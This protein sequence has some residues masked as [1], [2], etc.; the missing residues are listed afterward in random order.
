M[1]H[2]KDYIGWTVG[3]VSTLGE[4]RAV[5]AQLTPDQL[6]FVCPK[7]VEWRERAI[8]LQHEPA[9]MAA[10]QMRHW[11]QDEKLADAWHNYQRGE[12]Q[13]EEFEGVVAEMVE[14]RERHVAPAD[15]LQVGDIV[16]VLDD[17][18]G[19]SFWH[20][21]RGPIV[22]IK[23]WH[24]ILELEDMKGRPTEVGGWS[25]GEVKLISKAQVP[26]G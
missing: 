15:E 22:S 14:P 6:D 20:G 18:S 11:E 19:D 24:F 10:E 8:E 17:A 21:K 23:L 12:L 26:R 25:R 7:L 5:L 13:R 1:A 16:Q 3:D 4:L 2:S 9:M